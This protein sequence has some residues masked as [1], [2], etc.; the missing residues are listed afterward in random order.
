M[1]DGYGISNIYLKSRDFHDLNP[2]DCGFERC[3]PGHYFGPA[4]RDYYLIHY[5]SSGSGTFK[6]ARGEYIVG[7]GELFVIRPGEVTYYSASTSDPWRYSWIGF[8]GALA[9]VFDNAPDVMRA[10]CSGYFDAMMSCVEY[11]SMREE[12][13]TGQLFLMIAEL[14]GNKGSGRS[15]GSGFA[16]RAANYIDYRYM[17]P[18]SVEE[19]ARRMSIDRRYLSRLF[20]CEYGITMQEYIV[21]TRMKH[22]EAFLREGYSVSQTAG[23]TGYT[24][25]FN[26]SKMFKKHFGVSPSEVRHTEKNFIRTVSK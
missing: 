16:A 18:L 11:E 26:F 15:Q 7:A 20:K 3:A 6:N 19:M 25:V 12:I 17:Y 4:I 24:D 1:L 13:I 23:M 9:S 14:F 21:R 22:A 5:V 10:E 2:V 8:R